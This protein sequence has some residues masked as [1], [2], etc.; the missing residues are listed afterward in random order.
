MGKIGNSWSLLKSS[1]A[2]IGGN[3]KLLLF[4]AMTT[5]LSV[6]ILLFFIAPV[7]LQSTGHRYNDSAHW[8]S[9][10]STVFTEQSMKDAAAAPAGEKRDQQL[11]FTGKA[12]VYLALIYFASMFLA[13]FFNT[14]FCHEILGAL[15][16]EPVSLLGGLRFAA[17]KSVSILMWSLLAG[18]VGYLISELERR[19]S[20]IGKIVMGL[21]G[22][23]WSVASVFAIPVLIETDTVNPVKM[24]R[25]SA[26][27]LRKT[28][29]ESLTG[30]VGLQMSGLFIFLL[31]IVFLG[32]GLWGAAQFNAPLA[33]FAVF[34]A[35]IASLIVF[36]YV[37]GVAGQVYR[38]ALYLYAA[39][40]NIPATYDRDAMDSA[41][42]MKS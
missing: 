24:L 23:A 2:V 30:Y 4:P 38:C 32:G 37:A 42:K 27:T 34:S 1:L 41:W 22:V 12:N 16:G 9:V 39:T 6:G 10:A 11:E 21:V 13:T 36:A 33:M 20:F 15:R 31:S 25:A 3:K 5:L 7:A 18:I 29:G 28:W 26:E 40:G 19:L 8:K 35:W 17:G 14:A